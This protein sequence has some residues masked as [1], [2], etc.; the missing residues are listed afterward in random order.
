MATF[1]HILQYVWFFY[2]YQL[3]FVNLNNF[4]SFL[5]IFLAIFNS[6]ATGT[7]PGRNFGHRDTSPWN[8]TKKAFRWDILATRIAQWKILTTRIDPGEIFLKNAIPVHFLAT[9]MSPGKVLEKSPSRW[10]SGPCQWN[11]VEIIAK[12]FRKWVQIANKILCNAK[13]W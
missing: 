3:F 6:F 8:F 9:G 5:V 13:N 7:H 4:S 1:T 2:N 12:H 10:L 11:I